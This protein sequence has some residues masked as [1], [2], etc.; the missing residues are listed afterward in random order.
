MVSAIIPCFNDGKYI[1][2]VVD[3]VRL[4][5]RCQEIIIVDDGSKFETEEVLKNIKGAKLVRH[6]KNQ[7]KA[8]AMLSGLKA[9]KN[10]A[11]VFIDADLV[12]FKT[13][14]F[15]RLA[16]AIESQKFD[17]VIGA[18]GKEVY[19]TSLIGFSHAY[20]GERGFKS[21]TELI[22][23]GVFEASGY[24]I[25]PA[26]NKHYFHHKKTSAV[27]MPGVSQRIK[28]VKRGFSGLYGDTKMVGQYVVYLG[29]EEF[30]F[31]INFARKLVELAEK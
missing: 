19:L 22:N 12:N 30:L 5:K 25:E 10:E 13:E 11:I 1:K 29:P 15:D 26:M 28:V 3:A 4:S 21:K 17:M 2:P 9:A 16:E 8:R 23:S 24:L 31:Q 7:G 6:Q 18:R 27:F 20:T 14:H